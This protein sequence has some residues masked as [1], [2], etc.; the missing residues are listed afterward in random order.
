[1]HMHCSQKNIWLLLL[2]QLGTSQGRVSSKWLLDTPICTGFGDRLGY[3]VSLSALARL[4]GNSTVLMEWCEDGQ[5]ASLSNPLHLVYIPKWTGWKYP[6]HTVLEHITFPRNVDFFPDGRPPAIPYKLVTSNHQAPAIEGIPATST[7]Y[8][9]ALKFADGEWSY[10]D[11]RQAYLEAGKEITS[12]TL[13]HKEKPYVLVHVRCPDHNTHQRDEKSFCTRKVIQR[14]HAAGVNVRVISNNSTM[15][16]R[17]L[18]GL[19]NVH[20]LE[21]GT[22]WADM[23]L[24]LGAAAIV[25]HA[26]EG[27]SSYTS[28]PAM[29]KEIPLI[30]TYKG[31]RHRYSFFL[32]YGDLPPEFYSCKQIR[33]FVGVAV[34]LTNSARARF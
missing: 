11:Y 27:W 23:S 14:L 29:A 1:M 33:N 22:A 34:N 26:S 18:E 6:L 16:S 21:Q 24:V 12:K 8:W 31:M 28:V 4:N 25:Q 19:H 30:N 15:T 10:E 2:F 17:W 13:K 32:Q 5:R 7:L 3:I 20:I 9:K